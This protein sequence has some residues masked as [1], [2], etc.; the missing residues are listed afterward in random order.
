MKKRAWKRRA[1]IQWSV[2][3]FTL[4]ILMVSAA[5]LLLGPARSF[6]AP[7]PPPEALATSLAKIKVTF[8]APTTSQIDSVRRGGETADDALRVASDGPVFSSDSIY[9]GVLT[10]NDWLVAGPGSAPAFA[11]RLA[12]GVLLKGAE[13]PMGGPAL[14]VRHRDPV[15]IITEVIVFVDALS[16]EF[17]FSSTI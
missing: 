7:P 2:V 14:G 5:F 11:N 6:A 8:T 1:T 13:V 4:S 17:L 16:G 12:Y 9:L 10:N 15:K 3:G